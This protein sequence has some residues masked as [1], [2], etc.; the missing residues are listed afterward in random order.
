M[1]PLSNSLL[2]LGSQRGS[3]FNA[4]LPLE[5]GLVMAGSLMMLALPEGLRER[6]QQDRKRDTGLGG[7]KLEKKGGLLM[8]G[9]FIPDPQFDGEP[10]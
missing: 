8:S 10:P 4:S 2:E 3:L 1:V 5:P 7:R 9:I 6:K